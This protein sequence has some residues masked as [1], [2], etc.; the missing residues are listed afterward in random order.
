MSNRDLPPNYLNRPRGTLSRN[1]DEDDVPLSPLRA[2]RGP[3]SRNRDEDEMNFDDLHND[4]RVYGML[5]HSG[6]GL[7]FGGGRVQRK[8]L[9]FVCCIGVELADSSF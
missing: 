7:L 6:D 5:W 8:K 9:G 4:F 3:L 2:P 1:Q